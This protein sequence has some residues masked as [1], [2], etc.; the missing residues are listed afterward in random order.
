MGKKLRILN[1]AAFLQQQRYIVA[2]SYL[3]YLYNG[4]TL[5][6]FLLFQSIFY[7]TVLIFDIPAGYIGDIFPRKNVLIFSYFLFV[8][9]LLLWIFI[10][11]YYTIL[12]GEILYGLSKAFYKGVSDG[13]IYDYLS[14]NNASDLMLNKYGKFNFFIS[15]GS[16]VSCLIGACIYNYKGFGLILNLELFFNILA[17]SILCF[18]PQVSQNIR[19]SSIKTH[20][21][22]I[23]QTLIKTVT[24]PQINI[25]MFIFGIFFGI[26]SVFVWLF[27]PLMKNAGLPVFIFGLIYFINHILRALGS[28][29]ANKFISKF[30]LPKIGKLVWI[31][32]TLSFILLI[33]NLHLNNIYACFA[34]LV[35]VCMAIGIQMMFNVG[36]LSRIQDLISSD[37]RATVSTINSMLAGMFSGGF[38]MLF[39]ILIEKGSTTIA[40]C[41]FFCLFLLVVI[42]VRKI[43]LKS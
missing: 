2:I 24:N 23:F 33:I 42:P 9:R 14:D 15:M 35:F 40:L 34:I 7:F 17:I 32:Y 22:N 28:L 11:N 1:F 36:N 4:L 27:Q 19:H 26:T 30:S 12:A 29:N 39:K 38:L 43:N 21:S 10:P 25:Y 31:L 41:T 13:Y 37:S 18:L 20:I 6:D 3:F 8:I 5:S 16:A